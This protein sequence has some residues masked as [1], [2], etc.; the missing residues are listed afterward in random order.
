MSEV[1]DFTQGDIR[2]NIIRFFFPMLITNLLQQIYSFA[3]TAIV[4]N[5][6]GDNAFAAVGNM[7]SLTFL[8]IGFSLGLANGFSVLMA[9][10]F[11]AKMYD[12]LRHTL[13][14][15]IQLCVFLIVLLSSLSVFFLKDALSLLRTDSVIMADCLTYG[16][17]IFGGLGASVLYNMCSC[18]LRAFG[19]SKTP[20][21]AIIFSSVLNIVLDYLFIFV[22][23]T[24]VEGA[25]IAT[26]VA[27]LA[28]AGICYLKLRKLDFI[29]LTREDYHNEIKIYLNLL[30]NGIPMAFMNSITA[31]GCMVVQ[32]FINGMGVIY[33]TAYSACI[34][35]INMFMTP[36]CSAGHTMSAYSSQNFGARKFDRIKKGLGVCLSIAFISYV[37]LGSVMFFFGR[38]LAEVLIEGEESI[39]LAI[40]FFPICGITLIFVDFLFVFRSGVQGMG[41]PTVPMCS[42]ILEMVFRIGS[43]MLLIDVVGFKAVAIAETSAWLSALLLNA[44]AFVL[45]INAGI[46][47]KGKHY[48]SFK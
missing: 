4:G 20:L 16:Y 15:T 6:L 33:T 1:L 9:Q 46:R 29:K 24:G 35:Y 36:A 21:R 23:R 5:G 44:V 12:E 10:R 48:S 8:I 25:A 41:Y 42:G 30:S 2:K 34:K 13:A 40:Q 27:Q 26:V 38:Q 14:A 37:I 45:I 47:G 39:G 17:I 18:T 43:I 7:S 32:Y 11:G 28:S 22:I 31:I 3:D 19:D